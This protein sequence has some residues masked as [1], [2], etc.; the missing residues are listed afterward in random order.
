MN[1]VK[2]SL[3]NEPEQYKWSS[4]NDFIT[5]RKNPIID[6]QFLTEVFGSIKNFIKENTKLYKKIVSKTV[7]DIFD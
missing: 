4:F 6:Q 2:D 5:D 1:P 7:F 3:T